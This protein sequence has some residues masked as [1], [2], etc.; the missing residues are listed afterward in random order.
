MQHTK[1]LVKMKINAHIQQQYI[2]T[3]HISDF[4]KPLND[5]QTET[6]KFLFFI[7]YTTCVMNKNAICI[8]FGL[9]VLTG[10]YKQDLS[11]AG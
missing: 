2:D 9:C 8:R 4:S 3:Y 1:I 10:S 11:R 5:Q 6:V 7:K